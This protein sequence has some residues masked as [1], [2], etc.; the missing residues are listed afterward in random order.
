MCHLATQKGEAE[1]AAGLSQR[2]M[3]SCPSC[4]LS[5]QLCSEWRFASGGDL[6]SRKGEVLWPKQCVCLSS[7][8]FLGSQKEQLFS[9]QLS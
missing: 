5:A 2:R 3:M 4:A 9:I 8:C 6:L 1:G 7:L